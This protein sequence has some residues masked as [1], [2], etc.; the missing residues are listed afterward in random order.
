MKALIIYS[1]VAFG[2]TLFGS[3]VPML[4]ATWAERHKWRLLAFSSG[5]LLAIAI[6]DLFPEAL[7]L[8]G[9][10]ASVAVLVTFGILFA[11]ENLTSAHAEG[12]G[13]F[14]HP[15]SLDRASLTALGALTLHAAVDGMAMGVSLRQNLAF[16][17]AISIAVILHK[18]VDGLTRTSLLQTADYRRFKEIALTGILAA[19]TPVGAF[20]SYVGAAHISPHTTG[21]VLAVSTGSFLYV[22]A[23]DLLPRLHESNDRYNLVFFLVGLLVVGAF[24]G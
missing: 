21:I 1:L 16:G 23:A 13:D 11:L 3:L 17:S 19:A 24:T 8:N 12:E 18:F 4:Q 22:G 20:L 6:L 5:V 15:R 2:I 7:A 9:K 14:L 10:S